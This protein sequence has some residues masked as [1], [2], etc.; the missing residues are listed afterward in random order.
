MLLH[1]DRTPVADFPALLQGYGA[2]D[3]ASP[4]R[5]TVPL[6]SLLRHRGLLWQQVLEELGMDAKY[7]VHLEYTVKPPLGAGRAS[8]TDAMLIAGGRS[9]AVEA[10]WTEPPYA[11]V[12]KWLGP[13]GGSENRK[14][15]LEGWLSLLRAHAG[16][17]LSV[18][19][20]RHL[21][22]QMVHRAATACAAGDRPGLAYLIFSPAPDGSGVETGPVLRGLKAL[23]DVLG[24]PAGFPLRMLVVEVLPTAAFESIRPLRKGE[25]ATSEAVRAALLG[26]PLF[27]FGA[28]AV[29][30]VSGELDVPR[31]QVA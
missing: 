11:T 13:D 17:D 21:S 25:T 9:C 4:S 8:H 20:V 19:D 14:R 12:H 22:Y 3:L 16:R 15:V 29:H 10:K 23:A 2:S 31:P 7:A 30:R 6:L 28:L 5:S 1:F 27:G 24:R 18:D 26:P